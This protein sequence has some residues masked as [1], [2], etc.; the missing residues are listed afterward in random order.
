MFGVGAVLAAVTLGSQTAM[1]DSHCARC[2]IVFGE[3]ASGA[4]PE[5]L[6]AGQCGARADDAR[7]DASWPF[8]PAADGS[9]CE[10]C[11]EKRA[12]HSRA[13][14]GG[15]FCSNVSAKPQLCCNCG[16][17]AGVGFFFR[18]S[19]ACAACDSRRRLTP[20]EAPGPAAHH[21][22]ILCHGLYGLPSE[23]YAARD[24]LRAVRGC[25]VYC[26]ESYAGEGTK[27]GIQELGATVA[28]EVRRV[29]DA[30]RR[31]THRQPLRTISFLGHS[32]GGLIARSA[33][34]Q[35]WSD[36]D[37]P[38][39]GTIAGLT[40]LVYMS[41]ASPHLGVTNYLFLPQLPVA[42]AAPLSRVF[43]GQTG[44][45]LFSVDRA[46]GAVRTLATDPVALKALGS[47]RTRRMYALRCGDLLVAFSRSMLVSPEAFLRRAHSTYSA[48]ASSSPA[49]AAA[50][51]AGTDTCL[52]TVTFRA[53]EG[54][55]RVRGHELA[56]PWAASLEELGW[57][58]VMVEF[59][60]GFPPN[61][62]RRLVANHKDGLR[63]DAEG[64]LV[65]VR[66]CLCVRARSIGRGQ[67]IS[68]YTCF[69]MNLHD[70]VQEG[71]GRAHLPV[72][73]LHMCNQR[74][75]SRVRR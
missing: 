6:G 27:R 2:G 39:A 62:H 42:M 48:S 67:C 26:C 58:K 11:G 74:V 40:P 65:P 72:A 29:V 45:D 44:V 53:S 18:P 55:D 34:Q 30:I 47:F 3:C 28:A 54:A 52:H 31:D 1:A 41:T 63:D 46:G 15:H 56:E 60:C 9:V 4:L 7:Q 19:R 38:A 24:K 13:F 43:A 66:V 71:C 64:N 51:A 22:V 5:T 35:L 37:G 59:D 61:G 69:S 21:L 16:K 33:I 17:D 50:A 57:Q 20:P 73:I 8:T 70:T 14:A 75:H 12:A 49:V 25:V 68:A 32:L 36:V 10:L 23:L